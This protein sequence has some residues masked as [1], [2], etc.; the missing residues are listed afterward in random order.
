MQNVMSSARKESPYL[1]TVKKVTRMQYQQETATE[2]GGLS[3]N[4]AP[5][6]HHDWKFIRKFAGI[7]LLRPLFVVLW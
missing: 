4:V 6:I 7:K 1:L 3:P 5:N 2:R